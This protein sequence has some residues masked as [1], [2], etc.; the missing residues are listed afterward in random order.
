VK[1]SAKVKDVTPAKAAAVKK[2]N[3]VVVVPAK[4]SPVPAKSVEKP[5]PKKAPAKA[6]A[7]KVPAKKAAPAKHAA[8]AKKAAPKGR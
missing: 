5:V 2:S 4:K 6:G 7:A 8:P 1:A 3:I